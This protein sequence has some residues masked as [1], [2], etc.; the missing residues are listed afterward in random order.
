[1]KKRVLAILLLAAFA[2]GLTALMESGKEQPPTVVAPPETAAKTH[3]T[4]YGFKSGAK[5]VEEMEKILH[6]YMDQHP[7]VIFS[8]EGDGS[9]RYQSH[10]FRRLESGNG[11]DVFMLPPGAMSSVAER[12]WIGSKVENLDH[13]P[14]IDRYSPLMKKWMTVDGKIPAVPLNMSAVGLLANMDILKACGVKA[15]PETYGA[16][17]EALRTIKEK[18]HIPLMHYVGNDDSLMF[19]VVGRAFAPIVYQETAAP[20]AW[21]TEDLFRE[22]LR[23]VK[24]DILPFGGPVYDSYKVALRDFAAK[25][26]TAFVVAPTW[27]L[28]YFREGNPRFS[29]R[30]VGLPLSEKG[31]IVDARASIPVGVNAESDHKKEA[32]KFLEF[33][34]QPQY[35]EAYSF[36][37]NALSPLRG[38]A[39]G[40]EIHETVVRLIN[41][42]KV[43]SDSSP[44]IPFNAVLLLNRLTRELSAGKDVDEL[45]LDFREQ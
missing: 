15:V 1:M 30:Y 8:Y 27:S 16:W 41:E 18:G 39:S 45:F 12:G 14:L 7:G 26:D 17:L 34:M 24:E 3:L 23:D 13:L 21:R 40:D 19:L 6:A 25:G 38:A 31:P 20:S 9:E 4:F 44:E 42:G 2:C 22:A 11:D 43:F 37:Q 33:M 28:V 36:Q 29:Y 10:L 5:K 32:L 35:I